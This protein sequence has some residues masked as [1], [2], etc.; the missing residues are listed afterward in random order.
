M[1]WVDRWVLLCVATICAGILGGCC[2]TADHTLA[3]VDVNGNPTCCP[4]DDGVPINVKVG[5]TVNFVNTTDQ[6]CT[7]RADAGAFDGDNVVSIKKHRCKKVKIAPGTEGTTITNQ[8]DCGPD[9]H[10]APQMIVQGS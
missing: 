9:D 2:S 7:V 3:I 6:K 8:V 1:A 10:G 5:E 4:G